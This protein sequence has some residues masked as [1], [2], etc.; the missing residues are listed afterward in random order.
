M[1]RNRI[2]EYC[3]RFEDAGQQIRFDSGTGLGV[4]GALEDRV[5]VDMSPRVDLGFDHNGDE[6]RRRG[7]WLKGDAGVQ[8]PRRM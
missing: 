8:E 5:V 7:N 4:T 2:A 1:S 6:A 3:G